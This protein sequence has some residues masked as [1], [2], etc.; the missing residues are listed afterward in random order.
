MRGITN[1]DLSV[2][3]NFKVKK[4]NCTNYAD[5][6]CVL[7]EIVSVLT[8]RLKNETAFHIYGFKNIGFKV[9]FVVMNKTER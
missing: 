7:Q 5:K 8:P 3:W 9:K 1:K 2:R 4:L 6:D